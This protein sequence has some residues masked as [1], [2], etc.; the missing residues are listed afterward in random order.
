M[1]KALDIFAFEQDG[2]FYKQIQPFCCNMPY[3]NFALRSQNAL[4]VVASWKP[5]VRQVRRFIW[6][7]DID[8]GLRR[9]ICAN[10]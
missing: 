10:L 2:I 4:F 9:E 8:A 3:Q 7:E 1:R 5:E 6:R